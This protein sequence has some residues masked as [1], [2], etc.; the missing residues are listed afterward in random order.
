MEAA[1]ELRELTATGAGIATAAEQISFRK[2]A[3]MEDEESAGFE[4]VS[5]LDDDETNSDY[6]PS[7]P[8]KD[9]MTVVA[10]RKSESF[11]SFVYSI[12]LRKPSSDARLGLEFDLQV[13]PFT[14]TWSSSECWPGEGL[15]ILSIADGPVKEHNEV[16]DC[17]HRVDPGDFVIA[18]NGV[19]GH[20]QK[21]LQ[22]C[23]AS[24]ELQIKLCRPEIMH[25]RIP[26]P[27]DGEWRFAD[28]GRVVVMT[29]EDDLGLAVK[30]S[31]LPIWTITKVGSGLVKDALETSLGMQVGAGDRIVG[32]S[33]IRG[34]PMGMRKVLKELPMELTILRASHV[35]EV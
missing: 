14:S 19:T 4:E 29:T 5:I 20:P 34:D 16:W 7:H 9:P 15:S 10:P 8:A 12:C 30:F 28:G 24:E 1:S 35:T 27:L 33:G 3:E 21:L 18:V 26:A 31:D 17:L 6:V 2:K 25:V 32:I 11:A 13:H 22:A 23:L